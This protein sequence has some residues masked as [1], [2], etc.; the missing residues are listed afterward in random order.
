MAELGYEGDER[1]LTQVHD[2]EDAA[3]VR[4]AFGKALVQTLDFFTPIVND[5]FLFGQIAAANAF[6]DVY[7]MG[8]EPYTAMNI[9]CFPAKTMDTRILAAILKGGLSK[10]REAGAVMA[11]GHSV[12][13]GEIKYGLS[14][15]GL[16]D[17]DRF[18]SNRGL[19]P[20][21]A[22]ILT[23]P[24]GTGVLA[25]A[26][27]GERPG[28]ETFEALIGRWAARLN[29]AGAKVIAELGLSAA[30][31]IT[32]FG[33]GGHALEMARASGVGIELSLEAVP[34]I[35][36]AVAF[37]SAGVLPGGSRANKTFCSRD[38]ALEG[39]VDPVKVDLV[40]D[41]QTSG[42]L[43]LAVPEHQLDAAR[44][45]LLE[46]GDLAEVIGRSLPVREGQALL[47]IVS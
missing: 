27:K 4:P 12:E 8:G 5:P 1:L 39:D 9:V 17:P 34:F 30:T 37:A 19:A 47:R 2:N 10:I 29:K 26:L 15:T 43:L 45:M 44:R 3:V 24:I 31:D 23:K 35:P 6:S 32:G 22:L 16:V 36:E 28:S 21:S 42:G 13:D 18:A 14:V 40:F 41:A 33:L 11:G 7:A 46:A 38:V 25:T 20:G